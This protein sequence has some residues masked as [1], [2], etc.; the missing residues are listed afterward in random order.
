MLTI[1]QS[2]IGKT[3]LS[4]E[5]RMKHIA[6]PV[7]LGKFAGCKSIQGQRPHMEDTYQS[8]TGIN[9]GDATSA[10]FAVFDGHGGSQTSKFAA[11]HLHRLVSAQLSDEGPKEALQKAFLQLD[12][13]WL[14][15]AAKG[16]YDDGSTA[17]VAVV[18]ANVLTVSNLGDSRCVLSSGGRAVDMSHDHKPIREDE[19]QRILDLGGRVIHYGTWRVEGILA[20]SRAFGDRRLKKFVTAE[21]EIKSRELQEQDDFLILASDGVWDVLSSQAAVDIVS[22]ASTPQ[23]AAAYLTDAAYSRGSLDNITSLVVDLRYFVRH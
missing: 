23:Q 19:K 21:P 10:F 9:N 7:Q 13:E 1:F 12:A 3:P 22:K 5:E 2:I 18:Q 14:S 16:N 4:D 17:I 20:V 6:L 8:V 15:L 11:S